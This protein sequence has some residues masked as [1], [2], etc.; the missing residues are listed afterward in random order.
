MWS[1]CSTTGRISTPRERGL[2]AALVVEGRDPD[3]AVGALLDGER[4][5]GVRHVHGEGG[6][7]DAYLFGVR[8]LVELRLVA[9]A[10]G[11]AE[12]H[13]LELLREVG[14]VDAAGLGA[15]GDDGLAGVVLAGEEGADL[16]LVQR[17]LD[18]GQFVLR[19][20]AGVRV[21]L[22]LGH[23]EE[24]R[25]IV[26]P[27]AEGLG[28]ADLGLEVAQLAGDLLRRLRVVPQGGRCRLLLKDD[29][30]CPQR[31]QV[32]DGLDRLHGRGEG[33]ELFGYIDDCH[34]SSVTAPPSGVCRGRNGAPG[35]PAPGLASLGLRPQTPR[36]MPT[37]HPTR[38]AKRRTY[39]PTRPQPV[40]RL[41]TRPFRPMRGSGGAAPR[42]D[43]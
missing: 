37:H 16:H 41:R 38:S 20:G 13:A 5:V 27:A 9:V 3:E 35:H 32:Q 22:L 34:A 4:A 15:D 28:L 39:L 17:L 14:G 18:G 11:P 30:F 31:V 19:L 2:T 25:E 21:V 8:R 33:L 24:D 36:P 40:R 1:V 7:L 43:G 12:V 6:R 26:D 10:L 23:L 29:D 42:R